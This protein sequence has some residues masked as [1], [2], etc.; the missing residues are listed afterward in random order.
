MRGAVPEVRVK[1]R[2]GQ[3][4]EGVGC[5][6]RAGTGSGRSFIWALTMEKVGEEQAL[7]RP[8]PVSL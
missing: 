7:T 3:R 5:L 2:G 6:G 1:Y 8:V 4:E